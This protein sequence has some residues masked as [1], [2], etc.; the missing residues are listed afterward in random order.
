M[1]CRRK[2]QYTR[3]MRTQ[4]KAHARVKVHFF[5][6]AR[7]E[8]QI[9]SVG[10]HACRMK[11]CTDKFCG[12]RGM[13]RHPLLARQRLCGNG[14]RRVESRQCV[15][16]IRGDCLNTTVA[17]VCPVLEPSLDLGGRSE[18]LFVHS[19]PDEPSAESTFV[20]VFVLALEFACQH[21]CLSLLRLSV[22]T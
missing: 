13:G 20:H 1:R 3:H 10:G 4:G 21:A 15:R 2:K 16:R 17:P 6:R 19:T 12:T 5:G 22:R 11:S 9:C 7:M 14:E 18:P 8:F